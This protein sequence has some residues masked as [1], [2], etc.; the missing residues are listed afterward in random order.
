M[1]DSFGALLAATASAL[2]REHDRFVL[3]IPMLRSYHAMLPPEGNST[4]EP[5]IIDDTPS[6]APRGEQMALLN[7][8]YDRFGGPWF[9]RDV[10]SILR[11][12][13]PRQLLI[14]YREADP[15]GSV[16]RIPELLELGRGVYR[17]SPVAG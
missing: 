16:E 14:V 17:T 10:I 8:V 13:P 5:L 9:D 4:E 7:E 6:S 1:G 2:L 12:R 3:T 11:D 15:K